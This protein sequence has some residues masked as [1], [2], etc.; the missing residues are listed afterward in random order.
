MDAM[1]AINANAGIDTEKVVPGGVSG[2]IYSR[3]ASLGY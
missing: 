2:P 3:F 1:D